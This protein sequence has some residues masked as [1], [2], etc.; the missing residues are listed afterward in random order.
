M[1]LIAFEHRTRVFS[2]TGFVPTGPARPSRAHRWQGRLLK[3]AGLALLPWMGHLAATLPTTEA[4]AWVTLDS[5]EALA[6]TAAGSSLLRADGRH[7][8]PAAVAA[9]LLVADAC[10]DLATAAPGQ[11]TALALVMAAAVE[12]PL[13]VLCA[14]LAVGSRESGAGRREPAARRRTPGR[15]RVPSRHIS[16]GVASAKTLGCTGVDRTK[17]ITV[18]ATHR[19]VMHLAL[20]AVLTGLVGCSADAS[21][22]DAGAGAPGASSGAEAPA[23]EKMKAFDPP[24]KFGKEI[25]LPVDEDIKD[26][27][28]A[29]N[30]PTLYHRTSAA[31]DAYDTHTGRKLWSSPLGR[32]DWYTG[33]EGQPSDD[34]TIPPV[35]ARQDGRTEVLFAY[36]DYTKGSG[37]ERDRTDVYLRSVDADSGKVSWTVRLPAPKGATVSDLEPAVIGAEGGTAAVR[38]LTTPDDAGSDGGQSATTYAVDLKSHRV[39]W[40]EDGFAG[41]VLDSGIVIGARLGEEAS[42]QAIDGWHS[43]E[44]DLVLAGL[45]LT[46]GSPRWKTEGHRGVEVER[47][48]GGFFVAGSLRDSRTG[49]LVPGAPDGSFIHCFD[50]QRSVIVCDTKETARGID[51]RT[52]KV[53]WTVSEDDPARKKPDVHNAFHGAV[54]ASADA[55]G[56]ILDARTGKDRSLWSGGSAYV[57]NE[58]AGADIDLSVYPATG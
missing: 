26:W 41:G 2:E 47:V 40:Q 51:A 19:H 42:F 49:E 28:F 17:E 45:A 24:V 37:T 43:R 12:I 25:A 22:K 46:D 29:L 36:A 18:R 31:L 1:S 6:L 4:V 5:F 38:V 3:G 9:V 34:Q 30:G 32:K 44:G 23:P 39:T 57:I 21:E 14:T 16:E 13:A 35:F 10:A 27:G 50:D 11:E 54:Y 52:R 15:P 53:L 55:D 58:Y 56:V 7:R 33:K 20:A 48:G 8:F